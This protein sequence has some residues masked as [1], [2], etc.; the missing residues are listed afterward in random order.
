MNKQIIEIN[1]VKLE[2]DMRH[3]KRI[4]LINVGTRVKVLKKLYNNYEVHHGIVIG[5]EPFNK[6]PT[7]VVAL[8]KMEYNSAKI[9]FLYY[10]AETKDTEIVVALNDD[11]AAIDKDT[12]IKSIDREIAA[13]D[14]KNTELRE[15][16]EYFLSKFASYW[17][18][19]ESALA[20]ATEGMEDL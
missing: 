2:V 19:L 20:A 7:I 13:N 4:D 15:R 17:Q 8:C 11:L 14:V 12:F 6:L 1:G 10:N 3:A 18:P 16:K 9:E 5:F